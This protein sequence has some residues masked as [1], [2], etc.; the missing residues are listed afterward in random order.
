MI[1]LIAAMS[2]NRVIGQA[3]QMPW[4]LPAELAYFK[5]ITLHKPVL[6]GKRTFASIGQAL[7]KRRNLVL[8]R[9]ADFF[10]PNCEI[11]SALAQA[12]AAVPADQELMIIGGGELYRQ[13]LPLAERLY[14]TFIDCE[15]PGDTFFP[16]W[17]PAAWR[18]TH[19]AH[20]PAN[21]DNPFSFRT[22]QLDRLS[23]FTSPPREEV[24]FFQQGQKSGGHL[25]FDRQLIR[26]PRRSRCPE[27]RKAD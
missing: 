24:N 18:E 13:T 1:S 8:T 20:Y 5:K 4:R 9:Q 14:L 25:L 3:G 27:P 17:D 6:M 2:N 10:A 11:F 21:A 7:P 16:Q 22:V 19:C 26:D 23:G 12:L 15:L